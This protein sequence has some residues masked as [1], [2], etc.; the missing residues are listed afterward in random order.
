M[1]EGAPV[2]QWLLRC[3]GGLHRIHAPVA[4]PRPGPCPP[5][6]PR[7]SDRPVERAL[8]PVSHAAGRRPREHTMTGH[9][10]PP[11]E[12]ST[13]DL[14]RWAVFSCV[15]VPV[16]LVLYGTSLMR[17]HGDR[18]RP[19]RRHGRL[20]YPP[21]P[22]GARRGPPGPGG[23]GAPS[24]TPSQERRRAPSRRSSHRR[25]HTGRL[26]GFHTP[27]RLFSANFHVP[28]VLGSDYP[29]TRVPPARIGSPEP[30]A[31]YVD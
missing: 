29:P 6:G 7:R 24:R 17:R 3:T 30:R 20:P 13:T 18:A 8:T 19:R 10:P 23:A 12:D 16:V 22:V 31:P 21:A 1:H 4:A 2:T 15:L 5:N 27:G 11:S 26:T 14:V 9:R 25:K 28:R